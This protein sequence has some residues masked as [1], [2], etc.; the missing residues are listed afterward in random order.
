MLPY[1]AFL[2]LKQLG[3]RDLSA[4]WG[5]LRGGADDN[6][7]VGAQ[8]NAV[9]QTDTGAQGGVGQGDQNLLGMVLN[10]LLAWPGCCFRQEVVK[11]PNRGALLGFAPQ[12]VADGE[13]SLKEETLLDLWRTER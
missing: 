8:W 7:D 9:Q 10:G 2:K 13:A 11:G 1:T 12:V 5:A 3:R 4:L 6:V